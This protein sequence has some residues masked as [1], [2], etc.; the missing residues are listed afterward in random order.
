VTR[1][2]IAAILIAC[3][4]LGCATQLY[5]DDLSAESR[6]WFTVES[7]GGGT[8]SG[9]LSGYLA[10]RDVPLDG[11]NKEF[12]LRAEVFCKGKVERLSDNICTVHPRVTWEPG[13]DYGQC[14][15]DLFRCAR[16][17]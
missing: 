10:D 1:K 11:V 4:P 6:G 2:A 17:T 14:K 15:M 5:E 3:V 7:A 13:E 12:W 16:T 9:N 8:F